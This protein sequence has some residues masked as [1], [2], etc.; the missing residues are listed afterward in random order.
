MSGS[1]MKTSG[2][3]WKTYFRPRFYNPAD[4]VRL[5]RAQMETDFVVKALG[6]RRGA[7]VLDLCCGPGR[8]S[9]LLARKGLQVTG[10][11]MSRPYL[12]EARERARRLRCQVRFVQGD[13]RAIPFR[14]EFDAVIDL[15]TSFGYF[16]R[17]SEN[18][19]VLKEVRKALRPG[20]ALLLD[21]PNRARLL[22]NC[23]PRDWDQSGSGFSL[24]ERQL[25]DGG[26]RVAIKVIQVY[27]DGKTA[28]ES[29]SHHV[30]DK[31]SMSGL[32][33]QAGLRP[34]RFWGAFSGAPLGADA[35]RLIVLARR[36]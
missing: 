21:V 18:L 25:F 14:S 16:H 30:Y 1:V 23:T 11:D 31:K 17:Q 19:R 29:F 20:G 4:P 35:R 32:L 10:L 9:V 22:R 12:D 2:D 15:F 3:W 26:R 33:K 27:S 6:L 34:V 36:P 8:H 24:E 5:K 13:M 7:G 28:Q